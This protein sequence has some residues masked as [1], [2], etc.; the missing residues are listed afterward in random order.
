MKKFL[1]LSCAFA[2]FASANA[3]QQLQTLPMANPFTKVSAVKATKMAQGEAVAKKAPAKA[4]QADF[5]GIFI[6][7][8]FDHDVFTSTADTLRAANVQTEDG[9][10][11][12]IEWGVYS[13]Y[14]GSVYGTYDEATNKFT[15]P[16]FMYI[17][18]GEPVQITDTEASP[19]VFSG[20]SQNYYFCD[21]EGTYDEA[22][23][24]IVLNDS[25]LGFA[26][27]VAEG[28]YQNQAVYT[29]WNTVLAK[30]N[31]IQSGRRSSDSWNEFECP[32]FMDFTQLEDGIVDVYNVFPGGKVTVEVDGTEA[33]M[34]NRQPMI[35]QTSADLR[36]QYGDY[37]YLTAC[38]VDEDDMIHL[39]TS[40][41]KW[42]EGTY[43]EENGIISFLGMEG[44]YGIWSNIVN[45]AGY[46]AGYYQ[47]VVFTP[48]S[49]ISSGV[50]GV[51]NTVEKSSDNRIFNLAG[52]QVGKDYKGIVIQNGV[53]K[54]QK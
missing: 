20:V 1:L 50:K 54:V 36:N 52:Q 47:D 26:F 12:N 41:T 38:D 33:F 15:V 27:I 45:Q 44:L 4:S 11:F 14:F 30:A 49:G 28:T 51:E 6:A 31:G 24:K 34:G 32:I 19:L 22:S 2:A 8:S 37:A 7:S 17:G 23:Q 40:D 5:T 39:N 18:G 42:I 46:G 9:K 53:K 35:Y 43:D 3:Q 10:T 13:N 16:A 21:F 29:N 48:V 25:I